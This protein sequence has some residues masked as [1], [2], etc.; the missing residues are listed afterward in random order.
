L[1]SGSEVRVPDG[2]F[3]GSGTYALQTIQLR[4]PPA[5]S[6]PITPRNGQITFAVCTDPAS[7]PSAQ[8]TPTFGPT[9]TINVFQNGN[10]VFSGTVPVD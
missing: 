9:A 3:S 10:L 8:M 7:C 5:V 6:E 2:P 1:I 4:L